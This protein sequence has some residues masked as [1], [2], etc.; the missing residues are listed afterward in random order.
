[1]KKVLAMVLV[2]TLMF[3]AVSAL[4]VTPAEVVG[5]WYLQGVTKEDIMK[6]EP[7]GCAFA[8]YLGDARF[9]F[10]RDKTAGIVFDDN[11]RPFT[12]DIDKN[13]TL[14]MTPPEGAEYLGFYDESFIKVRED[15]RLLLKMQDYSGFASLYCCYV[16]GREPIDSTLPAA[17]TA[18]KE[19]DFYGTW[20][21]D[22]VAKGKYVASAA[23]AG[24]GD[25]TLT[26]EFA[27]ATLDM[28][29]AGS[30]IELTN[31]V[32]NKLTCS[33][34]ALGFSKAGKC[35]IELNELGLSVLIEDGD[36]VMTAYFL[37]AAEDAAN[38]AS[39][40]APETK[41]DEKPAA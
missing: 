12:W 41:S 22:R 5:T 29:G 21:A 8:H 18:E 4:A 17:V 9:E 19:D 32:D 27:Q 14:K 7:E 11:E 31:Y 24:L 35:T 26:I 28:P 6:G 1:M 2:L 23:D 25:A 10:N 3:S 37:P 38:T 15:G 30:V 20:V 40:A 33:A 13:G 39:E 34:D 16:F 36:T